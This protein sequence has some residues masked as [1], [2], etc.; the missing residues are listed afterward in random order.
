MNPV[1][2]SLK[3]AFLFTVIFNI[4][5][6]AQFKYKISA[7]FGSVPNGTMLYLYSP[8]DGK[9]IDSCVYNNG[10]MIEGKSNDILE[11]FIRDIK[12][13]I[14]A[15]I[16]LEPGKIEVAGGKSSRDFTVKG[17]KQNK[18]FSTIRSYTSAAD[19]NRKDVLMKIRDSLYRLGD[20]RGESYNDAVNDIND[21]IQL[22]VDS[23]ELKHPDSYSLLQ[24]AWSKRFASREV[25]AAKFAQVAPELRRHRLAGYIKEFLESYDIKSVSEIRQQDTAG[26]Q[27]TIKFPGKDYILLDIWASWCGPCR[28]NAG[29]LKTLSERYRMVNFKIVSISFDDD[30]G[31]WKTA[32]KEDGINWLS[33]CDL[34]GGN[35]EYGFKYGIRS[36]PVYMLISPD[37]TILFKKVN[38]IASVEEE[39]KTV[40]GK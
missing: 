36:I 21:S 27:H 1:N 10:L 13:R 9:N 7:T 38:E 28:Q 37:G 12:Y 3:T 24:N 20:H 11:C 30:L 16:I 40:F 6:M 14:K 15:E 18:Y 2:V 19:Q 39:L 31:K 29:K 32:M 34:K 17:G 23:F 8:L 35:N 26:V 25:M 33:L 5:G 22:R 4:N